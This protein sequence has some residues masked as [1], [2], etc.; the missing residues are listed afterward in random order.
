[1]LMAELLRSKLLIVLFELFPRHKFVPSSFMSEG[2]K[3]SPEWYPPHHLPTNG[4]HPL[5]RK[6]LSIIA[7]PYLHLNH[8]G[9]ASFA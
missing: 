8:L 7:L 9:V 4:G 3:L 5:S 2:L 6:S 1:M